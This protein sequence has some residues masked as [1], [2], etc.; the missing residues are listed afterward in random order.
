M[1]E[2]KQL[3]MLT[4]TREGCGRMNLVAEGPTV[5]ERLVMR[6]WSGGKDEADLREAVIH[7]AME[8]TRRR[9]ERETPN[10][11]MHLGA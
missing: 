5:G 7:Y 3:V 10:E 4:L 2:T 11:Q 1:T 6:Y 8:L 9:M